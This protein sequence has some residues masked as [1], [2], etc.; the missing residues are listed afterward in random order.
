MYQVRRVPLSSLRRFVGGRGRARPH[1]TPDLIAAAV[2]LLILPSLR[3]VLAGAEAEPEELR[4]T[5]AAA[6]VVIADLLAQRFA[7]ESPQIAAAAALH[8]L[9]DGQGF[10]EAQ[11]A[12]EASAVIRQF[13]DIHPEVHR[14]LCGRF[15]AAI[16][17]AVVLGHRAQGE[18]LLRLALEAFE[19][20]IQQ[21]ILGQPA[22]APG[23]IHEAGLLAVVRRRWPV[24]QV[25]PALP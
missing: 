20:A 19:T 1:D 11:L 24:A 22:P 18:V 14:V 9:G 2:R 16:E 3:D 13:V 23:P 4:L 21:L 25:S 12:G 5:Y 17:R 6:C 8:R 7:P 15:D 10:D